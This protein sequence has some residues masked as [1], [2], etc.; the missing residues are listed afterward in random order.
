MAGVRPTSPA[1]TYRICS[2]REFA[3]ESQKVLFLHAG[4]LASILYMA[5]AAGR[6]LVHKKET[7]HR[8]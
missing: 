2:S 4:E 5:A 6:H 8:V 7:V 1:R 3:A